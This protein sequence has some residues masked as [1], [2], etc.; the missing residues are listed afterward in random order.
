MDFDPT[1][2][3]SMYVH[4]KKVNGQYHRQG[5]PTQISLHQQSTKYRGVFIIELLYYKNKPLMHSTRVSIVVYTIRKCIAL[6]HMDSL[7]KYRGLSEQD[8]LH[9]CTCIY[10]YICSRGF[11]KPEFNLSSVHIPVT[12]Y[13]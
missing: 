7:R 4:T 2:L 3:Y 10:M 13:G 11:T 8:V 12:I 9:G 6:L 5:E 1:V